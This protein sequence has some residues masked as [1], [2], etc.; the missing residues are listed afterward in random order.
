VTL[1]LNCARTTESQLPPEHIIFGTSQRM[2]VVQQRLQKFASANVPV[3]IQGESGTG[4]G[5]IARLIHELSPLRSGPF[6]KVSCPAIPAALLESELF[7]HEKGG[8]TGAVGTKVGQ[9]ERAHQGTLFLDE[10]SEVNLSLQSKLL[11]VLQD[12]RYWRIGAAEDNVVEARIVCATNRRL[13]TEVNHGRFRQDLFY[14][15]N[16]ANIDLPPLRQ[17]ADD[18]V[19]LVNYFIEI[20]HAKYGSEIRPLSAELVEALRAYHWPGNIRELQ[21]LIRRYAILGTTD[22]ITDLTRDNCKLEIQGEPI[23]FSR[24]SQIGLKKLTQQAVRRLERRIILNVLQANKWNRRKSARFLKISYRALLYKMRDAGLSGSDST[25]EDLLPT[26]DSELGCN[27]EVGAGT[28]PSRN[29]P[30]SGA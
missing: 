5:V 15:I 16:V 1:L 7:G 12:G 10:I 30:M 28:K 2:R 3:L 27:V 9:V 19:P 25:P 4:K 13:D 6:V 11:Q 8:F 20:Y 23:E 29:F 18:I 21:N 22:V 24:D 26:R 14:R 17:R